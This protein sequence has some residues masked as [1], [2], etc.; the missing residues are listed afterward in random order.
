MGL[1][2]QCKTNDKK[3]SQIGENLKCELETFIFIALELKSDVM[4]CKPV[5]FSI[6]MK[7]EEKIT[8]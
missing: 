5:P 3:G 7:G 8:I 1:V 2:Y 4:H 6:N